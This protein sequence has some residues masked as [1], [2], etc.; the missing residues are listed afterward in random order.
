VPEKL[1]RRGRAAVELLEKGVV[2]LV[3]VGT[4]AV[5]LLGNADEDKIEHDL[6]QGT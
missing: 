4:H 6:W 2:L 5:N 3:D 1:R